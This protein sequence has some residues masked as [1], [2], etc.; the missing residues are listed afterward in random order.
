[1]QSEGC[2]ALLYTQGDPGTEKAHGQHLQDHIPK[3]TALPVILCY[4]QEPGCVTLERV[5][6]SI[7]GTYRSC[8]G[9]TVFT[10]IK[11]MADAKTLGATLP[12]SRALRNGQDLGMLKWGQAWYYKRSLTKLC[13]C[14]EAPGKQL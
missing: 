9:S 1:M 8:D 10:F 4:F 13:L 14:L 5:R 12:V 6:A 11:S 7:L 3:I 2:I